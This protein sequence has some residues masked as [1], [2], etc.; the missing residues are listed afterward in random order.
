MNHIVWEKSYYYFKCTWIVCACDYRIHTW[1]NYKMALNT[2]AN[3][4]RHHLNFPYT[5]IGS[6]RILDFSITY[7]NFSLW[8][9]YFSKAS[10]LMYEDPLPPETWAVSSGPWRE[11]QRAKFKCVIGF[12]K[13][14]HWFHK[15][16]LFSYS[17]KLMYFYKSCWICYNT[18]SYFLVKF[19]FQKEMSNYLGEIS[20]DLNSVKW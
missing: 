6:C 11:G 16:L 4:K 5:K 20:K 14:C 18:A 2:L 17:L 7:C 1:Y 10:E 13:V 3:A 8:I 9:L 15:S 12:T 19:G